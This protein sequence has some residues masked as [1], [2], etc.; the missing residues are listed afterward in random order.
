MAYRDDVQFLE[1]ANP[2][3]IDRNAAEFRRLHTLIE[4]TDDAFR[5]AGKVEWVSEARDLY[6]RRLGE[7]KSLADALSEAFR[8]AGSALDRY[9]DA[10]TTAK[11]HY[12][13]GQHTEGRLSEVM[14]REA[15]AVTPTARAAEPLRQWEDLRANTGVLDW[16][17][18]VN[19]DVDAIRKTLSAA[20]T[21]PRTTTVTRS[22][23]SP[24]RGSCAL[25]T[26]GRRTS[27]Y[28]TTRGLCPMRP[29]S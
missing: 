18:E 5:K 20:T 15:Q 16:L 10:V 17:A 23:S 3:L 9:A 22:A 28:P 12:E 14:A 13:N 8:K 21:R 2:T 6:V 4:S 25:P 1:D 27:R 29:S 24:P 11:V 26:S 19:V 7:S